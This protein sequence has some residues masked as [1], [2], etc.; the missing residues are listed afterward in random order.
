MR[1]V[2]KVIAAVRHR[3]SNDEEQVKPPRALHPCERCGKHTWAFHAS[4]FEVAMIYPDCRDQERRSPHYLEACAF[5]VEG[6][7][8]DLSKEMRK[9]RSLAKAVCQSKCLALPRQSQTSRLQPLQLQCRPKR[10]CGSFHAGWQPEL[11]TRTHKQARNGGIM[12]S[13]LIGNA[14]PPTAPK[15][16][17]R[18]RVISRESGLLRQSDHR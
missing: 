5:Y 8:G 11:F 18:A 1:L 16:T 7:A 3:R 6:E 17:A 15:E 2:E 12:T 4:L 10:R 13:S 9:T 14:R